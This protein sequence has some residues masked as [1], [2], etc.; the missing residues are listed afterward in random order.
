M[1]TES[2][3]DTLAKMGVSGADMDTAVD[4]T[5]RLVSHYG[6]HRQNEAAEFVGSVMA[7]CDLHGPRILLI[8]NL[9]HFAE[10]VAH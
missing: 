5:K 3:R 6:P 10:K 2:A 7:L 4:A 1:T 9:M 8:P